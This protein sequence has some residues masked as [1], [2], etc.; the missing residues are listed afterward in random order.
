MNADILS[1]PTMLERDDI[2]F[3]RKGTSSFIRACDGAVALWSDAI[4]KE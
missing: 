4:T 2:E 1:F 3:D